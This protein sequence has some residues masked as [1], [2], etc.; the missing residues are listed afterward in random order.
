[1]ESSKYSPED[2]PLDILLLL[3]KYN[4]SLNYIHPEKYKTALHQTVK[5]GILS[6]LPLMLSNGGD[7]NVVDRKKRVVFNMIPSDKL[8]LSPYK[9]I[10]LILQQANVHT[11][12]KQ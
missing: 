9:Q 3:L 6:F 4:A 11:H 7:P 8:N 12:W 10:K 5:Y 2:P 1:V